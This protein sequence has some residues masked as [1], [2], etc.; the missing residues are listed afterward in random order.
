MRMGLYLAKQSAG[1]W[2]VQLNLYKRGKQFNIEII[3][4]A[5]FILQLAYA[6]S[7]LKSAVFVTFALN[8]TV[9]TSLRFGYT[10]LHAYA[11]YT[12]ETPL[13]YL[14]SLASLSRLFHSY[15]DEPIGRWGE[16]GVP[17][18]KQPDAPASRPWLV[19]HVASA[20]LKPTP[21]TAMR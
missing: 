1:F 21:V 16:T 10:C 4:Q 8:L 6:C 18:E 11:R 17:R 20:G 14:F 19:S 9:V 12:F 7:V 5:S 2:M 13:F 15:R 3:F